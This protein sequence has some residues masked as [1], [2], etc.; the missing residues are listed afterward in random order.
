MF[1]QTRFKFLYTSFI[2]FLIISFLTRCVL[3]TMS[4][5]SVDTSFVTLIKTF[6]I[7]FFYDIVTAFY[8]FIPLTLYLLIIPAKFYNSKIHRI[9]LTVIAVSIVYAMIFNG[10]SEYFFWEEFGKRFNFIAVDYLVY[11][12]EVIKNIQESYPLPIILTT[13]AAASTAT[14]YLFKKA[15]FVTTD[16]TTFIQRFKYALP[17]LLAPLLFFNMLDK[18][19]LSNISKNIYNNELAKNG[20]YSLFSA[21]RHNEL[22]YDEFYK[23]LDHQTV[24]KN[25]KHLE[26]FDDKTPKTVTA[27][28]PEQKY[29]VILIMVESL[30][31]E[32]MGIFGD[33]KGLTPHLDALTKKSLFFNNLF[34]TGTRT[35][36]GMEA[37]TLSVP[38]TPGRSIVKRPKNDNMDSI[39]TIFKAKGYDNKFIY[40]GHGYFDNMNDFFSKNGFK[41]VDRTDFD[42]NEISFANVWGVCDEDLFGKVLKA[43]DKSYTAHKPFFSFVMTTSNHRPYTYPDGKIDIPT[44]T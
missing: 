22:D 29:N 13:I 26:G 25:L 14:V 16:N 33:K 44:H 2:A 23:T 35:V 15:F 8:Y 11:T 28:K 10:V 18:Q 9:I 37:V 43:A 17:F 41:I 36:R 5:E 40:A 19:G 39:G 42:K 20:L 38:P 21:F 34:A 24:M 30:S 7:G 1:T 31:A 4:L 6:G 3:M 12:H 32:Y 27:Q